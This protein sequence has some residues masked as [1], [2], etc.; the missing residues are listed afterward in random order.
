MLS[1]YK[2]ALAV[3]NIL[4]DPPA[5]G[6]HLPRLRRVCHFYRAGLPIQCLMELHCQDR[7]CIR[8]RHPLIMPG[9][10]S[11][12]CRLV[13]NTSTGNTSTTSGAISY[14]AFT[15]TSGERATP[16]AGAVVGSPT[17]A[18][19]SRTVA[20]S[21]IMTTRRTRPPH[22]LNLSA[23]PMNAPATAPTNIAPGVLPSWRRSLRA[24]SMAA[25]ACYPLAAFG[26]PAPSPAP[27]VSS[28]SE[29]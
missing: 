4:C 20:G 13:K 14:C 28:T 19:I 3:H 29:F 7:I 12:V 24:L 16:M 11:Q 6:P 18:S 21:V 2:T 5:A 9:F 15:S 1:L 25:V 23:H 22:S 8:R 27:V 26:Q 17:C 10:R